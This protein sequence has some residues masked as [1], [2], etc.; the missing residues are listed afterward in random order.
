MYLWD[1]LF[2]LETVTYS[3]GPVEVP[4]RFQKLAD[5][6]EFDT[7]D[8]HLELRVVRP[9]Q[10][11]SFRN[12]VYVAG[13]DPQSIYF[14]SAVPDVYLGATMTI[15]C[16][17]KPAKLTRASQKILIDNIDWLILATAAELARNDPA[18]DDQFGTLNGL[19]NIEYRKMQTS[20]IIIVHNQ[21]NAVQSGSATFNMGGPAV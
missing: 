2:S 7:S 21:P 11:K 1:S 5:S 14:T 18:K 10:R 8:S 13:N 17:L 20:A 4:D 6:V 16:N 12:A 15:P 19:A 3:G 9:I